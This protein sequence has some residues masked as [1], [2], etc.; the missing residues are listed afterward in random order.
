MSDYVYGEAIRTL[1]PQNP[2]EE[3]KRRRREEGVAR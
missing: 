2:N 3:V 1:G